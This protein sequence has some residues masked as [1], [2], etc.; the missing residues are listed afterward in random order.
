MCL[1]GWGV[2]LGLVICRRVMLIWLFSLGMRL[3]RMG[4]GFE[5]DLG[6]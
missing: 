2:V 1:F 3:G 4:I 5:G 6:L